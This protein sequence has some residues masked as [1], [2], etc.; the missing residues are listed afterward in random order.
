M[1]TDAEP[2]FDEIGPFVY[3]ENNIYSDYKYGIPV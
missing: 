2:L 1:F 3:R